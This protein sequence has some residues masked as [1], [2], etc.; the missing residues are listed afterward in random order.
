MRRQ[1]KSHTRKVRMFLN[2][3]YCHAFN[4]GLYWRRHT[5]LHIFETISPCFNQTFLIS[6]SHLAYFGF[7]AYLNLHFYRNLFFSHS[8]SFSLVGLLQKQLSQLAWLLIP[9]VSQRY[10]RFSGWSMPL[11]FFSLTF[12]SSSLSPLCNTPNCP[13]SR[14]GS[15]TSSSVCLRVTKP[16]SLLRPYSCLRAAVTPLLGTNKPEQSTT[17][18][19]H[20][21][22]LLHMPSPAFTP[23]SLWGGVKPIPAILS[24]G[25]P[26]HT[27]SSSCYLI[28]RGPHLILGD[29]G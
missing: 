27:S 4:L 19:N 10:R 29:T 12:V 25:F 22:H 5:W 28:S 13:H 15:Q 26:I 1:D 2:K 17:V 6:Q 3:T 14:G 8:Y 20:L 16:F 21:P 11:H 23:P 7:G 18:P 24:F 9:W